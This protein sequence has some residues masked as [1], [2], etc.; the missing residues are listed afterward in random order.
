[1]HGLRQAEQGVGH[2]VMVLVILV[3]GAIGAIGY[4]L[5]AH[6]Q[7]STNGANASPIDQ[8]LLENQLNAPEVSNVNDLDKALDT[9]DQV[10]PVGSAAADKVQLDAEAEQL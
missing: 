1:M 4:T 10:D 9:L 2:L 6:P 7:E 8:P 5:Y 3:F